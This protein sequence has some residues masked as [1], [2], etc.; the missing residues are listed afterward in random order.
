MFTNF[1][2]GKIISRVCK[3][4]KGTGCN[5]AMM[6]KNHVFNSGTMVSRKCS[7]DLNQPI[8]KLN[9]LHNFGTFI[10]HTC[11]C[12]IK[13]LEICELRNFGTIVNC[14][15]T[16]IPIINPEK[17]QIRLDY[18]KSFE[19]PKRNVE[20]DLE[21]FVIKIKSAMMRLN[22]NLES[23]AI[24]TTSYTLTF[25]SD[26]PIT[27]SEGTCSSGVNST[28]HSNSDSS[29]GAN[30]IPAGLEVGIMGP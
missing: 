26:P 5:E 1:L 9:A 25:M 20:S 23:E 27:L 14:K 10:M 22:P 18:T 3:C 4:P 7:G 19:M 11:T 8:V 2:E 29:N 28:S 17:V 21:D 15:S 24:N 13:L 6:D 12:N 16:C 30:R